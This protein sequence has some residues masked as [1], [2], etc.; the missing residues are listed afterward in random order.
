MQDQNVPTTEAP[1][2]KTPLEEKGHLNRTQL[3]ILLAI[4]SFF[5]L[6]L[7]GYIVWDNYN[8]EPVVTRT[9][10][11]ESSESEKENDSE[12]SET[13]T[14]NDNDTESVTNEID[15]SSWNTFTYDNATSA[16]ETNPT[17]Y[18][19]D[20]STNNAWLSYSLYPDTESIPISFS[21]PNT[22]TVNSNGIDFNDDDGNKILLL[23]PPGP[24]FTNGPE[25]FDGKP[26]TFTIFEGGTSALVSEEPFTFDG[27]VGTRRIEQVTDLAG[28][29]SLYWYCFPKE[30]YVYLLQFV[31]TEGTSNGELG[32]IFDGVAQTFRFE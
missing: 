11:K 22:W 9:V 27:T 32:N 25:C 17:T 18:L 28:D 21:Y 15:T 1:K 14:L 8:S 5:V 3:Y 30:D 2:E 10:Y 16:N 19:L 12:T 26:E 24:V 13:G 7:C 31:D 4:L 23:D 20:D 6:G 29:Y